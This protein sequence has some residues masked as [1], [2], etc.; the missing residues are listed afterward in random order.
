MSRSDP[1]AHDTKNWWP[2][3]GASAAIDAAIREFEESRSCSTAQ[4]ESDEGRAT[5]ESAD[6]EER[7]SGGK[8]VDH[9]DE[10]SEAMKG[11][12]K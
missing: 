8:V 2:K 11:G 10:L 1:I 4:N 7:D 5:P 9:G 12:L 6:S 3:S